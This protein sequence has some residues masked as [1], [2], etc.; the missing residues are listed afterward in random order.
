MVKLCLQATVRCRHAVQL[1][2]AGAVL[3]IVMCRDFCACAIQPG[4]ELEGYLPQDQL[5]ASQ[6][7]QREDLS[8]TF[9]GQNRPTFSD[10]VMGSS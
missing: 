6:M 3:L 8:L 4:A 9:D 5:K 10:V 7:S 2:T 1:A